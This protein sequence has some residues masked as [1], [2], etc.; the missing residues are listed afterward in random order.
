M[1]SIFTTADLFLR[2]IIGLPL[3][4]EDLANGQAISALAQSS[5]GQLPQSPQNICVR[6]C[7]QFVF[8]EKDQASIENLTYLVNKNINKETIQEIRNI[9]KTCLV[10][11][12]GANRQ[13]Q[14]EDFSNKLF[15]VIFISDFERETNEEKFSGE[16]KDSIGKVIEALYWTQN[17]DNQKKLPDPDMELILKA[18]NLAASHLPQIVATLPIRQE[19]KDTAVVFSS[20]EWVQKI[21]ANYLNRLFVERLSSLKDHKVKSEHV[22]IL[23]DFLQGKVRSPVQDSSFSVT[24]L[25]PEFQVPVNTYIKKVI[26]PSA[27]KFLQENKIKILCALAKNLE[28]ENV[29]K[30]FLAVIGSVESQ[31]CLKA[32]LAFRG[33]SV[34]T[35]FLEKNL[36]EEMAPICEAIFDAMKPNAAGSEEDF[37]KSLHVWE[38]R[39]FR[40]CVSD[41]YDKVA[42]WA[43]A[44]FDKSVDFFLLAKRSQGAK[45]MTRIFFQQRLKGMLT[46]ILRPASYA[47]EETVVREEA[48]LHSHA[49]LSAVQ[50]GSNTCRPII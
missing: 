10:C 1:N 35:A 40:R 49:I 16:L 31:T 19:A 21:A 20:D 45:E 29:E 48:R 12:D 33:D 4:P 32:C 11:S 26:V 43:L 39:L 2:T 46:F 37:Q 50:A 23:K 8:P 38:K 5:L 42:N 22:A 17:S 47:F 25:V 15:K 44:W 36:L 34:E 18:S 13:R 28:R 30:I 3:T 14:I 7:L 9:C 41:A 24:S 6:E 27:C